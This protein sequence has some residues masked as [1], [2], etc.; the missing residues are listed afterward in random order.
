VNAPGLNAP[1]ILRA[2]EQP[3]VPWQN[4]GGL[5]RELAVHPPG[6]DLRHFLW[7]VSVAT[8]AAAG[9]F[10]HFPGIERRMAILAGRLSLSIAA[11]P[12]LELTPEDAP[13]C[14]PGEAA[15]QAAPLAGA[16]TDLNVMT[17]RGQCDARLTRQHITAPLR[18]APAASMRLILALTD[19]E[20]QAGA[21]LQLTRLDAL[22][23]APGSTCELRPG[24]AVAELYLVEFIAPA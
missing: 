7:R 6:S 13:I 19:L 21:P 5:T 22:Y 11:R 2:A 1:R 17:R 24:R 16:V 23:L 18:L 20:V 9:P 15:V 8:V 12:P 14:F 4:G 3:P 10:S